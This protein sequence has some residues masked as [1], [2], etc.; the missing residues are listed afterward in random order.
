[1]QERHERAVN[2]FNGTTNAPE[3]FIATPRA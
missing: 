1:V 3:N 2:K